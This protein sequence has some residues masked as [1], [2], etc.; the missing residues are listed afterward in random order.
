[1]PSAVML[2]FN[3]IGRKT[4]V[5]DAHEKILY[6]LPRPLHTD[7]VHANC[8]G[9]VVTFMSGQKNMN[10]FN[11][12]H[13]YFGCILIEITLDTHQS[14]SLFSSADLHQ[15]NH[16]LVGGFNPLVFQH[17]SKIYNLPRVRGENFKI[18]ETTHRTEEPVDIL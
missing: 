13:L 2:S 5:K 1:M 3:L 14:Y 6:I 9:A 17:E 8:P 12:I 18:F 10:N 11:C 7:C 4:S 15:Q 16:F